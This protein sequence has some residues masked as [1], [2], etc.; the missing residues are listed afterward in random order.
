MGP[1]SADS[2]A[3]LRYMGHMEFHCDHLQNT[4]SNSCLRF[5]VNT[6]RN[7]PLEILNQSRNMNQEIELSS[8]SRIPICPQYLLEGIFLR[9][10]DPYSQNSTK[11]PH[12]DLHDSKYSC[13]WILLQRV[14]DGL[15]KWLYPIDL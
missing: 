6:F 9:E 10:R 11:S 5:P 13:L 1:G 7:T 14:C 4:P 2:K 12:C 15:K 3:H 8:S